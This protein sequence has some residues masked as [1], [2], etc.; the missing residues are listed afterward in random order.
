MKDRI[1]RR[2]FFNKGFA[3]FGTLSAAEMLL[4]AHEAGAVQPAHVRMPTLVV[5]QL[6]GGNDG[7]NMVV[8][9]GIGT[10][11]DVRPKISIKQGQVLTLNNQVGLNGS[12]SG[13]H[14]IYKKNKLAVVQAVGYPNPNRSHFRSIEIWQTAAPERYMPTGWLG[15]FLDYNCSERGSMAITSLPAVNVDPV[16]PLTVLASKVSVPSVKNVYDFRFRTDPRYIDDR[17]AQVEAFNDI[18]SDYKLGRKYVPLLTESGIEASKSSDYLLQV[19][20][21]YQSTIKYPNGGLGDGLRFIAQLIC[22]GLAARVY[23]VGLGGF[24]THT[25]Q[26]NIQN[27]L[28]KQLSDAMAAFQ[29]DLEQHHL[30]RNVVTMTFSEFG[31]RVNENGSQGTDHGTALPM[32]V[33]GTPV[34]GG[35][36]GDHASLTNLDS[37]DLRYK[38]DFRSVYATLLDSY[39]Q[40][41]SR[42]VLGDKYEHLGFV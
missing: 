3:A 19:V 23:T 42:E 5:I 1:S 17:R 41:D 30:D 20:R 2:E 34:K 8:P 21:N 27:N 37:G 36:Y 22:G 7:M 14:S 4:L 15:R 40:A 26:N 6:G 11:Y 18:Y 33:M 38:I 10:Y 25:N 9:F 16:A 13:L 39:M 29:T 32:F 12:M 28:L 35:V 31:R 24:D